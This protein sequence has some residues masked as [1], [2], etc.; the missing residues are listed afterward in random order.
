MFDN[1]ILNGAGPAYPIQ[2][3]N[4]W[5]VNA[6]FEHFWNPRWRTSLYGGYTRVWY[7]QDA[8]TYSQ[9]APADTGCGH[10]LRAG[11]RLKA[12]YGRR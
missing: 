7:D 12:R 6:A 2:L 5:S 4:A 8:T 11:R 9:P 10:A 3:T 1:N